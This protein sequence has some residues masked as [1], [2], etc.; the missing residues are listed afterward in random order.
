MGLQGTRAG[1]LSLIVAR[2]LT[3]YCFRVSGLYNSL[4]KKSRFLE[5]SCASAESFCRSLFFSN[6]V[7]SR[8]SL[9]AR[10][11]LCFRHCKYASCFSIS[12]IIDQDNLPLTVERLMK[13]LSPIKAL[14]LVG[15]LLFLLFLPDATVGITTVTGSV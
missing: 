4:S 7:D 11:F 14:P 9:I 1:L 2:L 6:L 3:W 8:V 13:L 15:E 10:S 12:S 5:K